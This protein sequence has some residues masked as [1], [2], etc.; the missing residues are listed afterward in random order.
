ME[1][2]FSFLSQA[3]K[4]VISR[5]RILSLRRLPLCPRG[6]SSPQRHLP[7]CEIRF[8]NRFS[9]STTTFFSL[10]IRWEKQLRRAEVT[11][12][13]SWLRLCFSCA[14][15]LSPIRNWNSGTSA[16]RSGQDPHQEW[17]RWNPQTVESWRR[18]PRLIPNQGARQSYV[19]FAVKIYCS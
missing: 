10:F 8:T 18:P 3:E 16:G 14:A 7:C 15:A 17:L 5:P 4:A 2:T 6:L 19:S 12:S 13:E 1:D 11:A 9:C